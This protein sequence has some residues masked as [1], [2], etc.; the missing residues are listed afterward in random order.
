[1]AYELYLDAAPKITLKNMDHLSKKDLRAMKDT[2]R[3]LYTKRIAEER[4][5]RDK[6]TYF[7]QRGKFRG[8]EAA[9]KH[10]GEMLRRDQE[11]R[12]LMQTPEF[13][14]AEQKSMEKREKERKS[15]VSLTDQQIM[16]MLRDQKREWI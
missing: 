5:A 7:K 6:G 8:R 4:E 12:R 15:D 2:I 11:V 10:R 1:L 9:D 3:R 13:K 14:Q 16:N